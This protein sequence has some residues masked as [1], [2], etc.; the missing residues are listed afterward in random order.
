M[1]FGESLIWILLFRN[2]HSRITPVLRLRNAAKFLGKDFPSELVSLP[3]PCTTT[4]LADCIEEEALS[5]AIEASV[6]A[7]VVHPKRRS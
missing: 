2:A 5:L 3:D 4:K 1:P 6:V 7:K